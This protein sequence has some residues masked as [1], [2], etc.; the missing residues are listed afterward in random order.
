MRLYHLV[1]VKSADSSFLESNRINDLSLQLFVLLDLDLHILFH[2]F[3]P[4]L[5]GLN[6]PLACYESFFG[7][8]SL[9]IFVV[10]TITWTLAVLGKNSRHPRVKLMSDWH[11]AQFIQF[12][13]GIRSHSN[14][15]SNVMRVVNR[16]ALRLRALLGVDSDSFEL[17]NFAFF[18]FRCL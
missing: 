17:L 13:W 12:L 7:V 3:K 14:S 10:A 18:S 1:A 16:V 4:L 11:L 9:L 5:S 2:T 15:I 8:F 6:L